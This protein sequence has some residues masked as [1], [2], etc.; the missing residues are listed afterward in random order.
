MIGRSST[1]VVLFL[2]SLTQAS[3]FSAHQTVP[4][5][6]S[7]MISV[8]CKP[9]NKGCNPK[10]GSIPTPC[11]KT[12]HGCK[13]EGGL[14]SACQGNGANCGT[15][16]QNLPNPGSPTGWRTTNPTGT[17]RTA[18]VGTGEQNRQ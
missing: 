5:T 7:G 4:A 9:G 2:S 13:I 8:A 16:G 1:V 18:P 12:V 6:N 11:G 17:S 10:Q 14:G 3:A 15:Q